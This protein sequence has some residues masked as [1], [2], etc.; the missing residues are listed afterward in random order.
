[1]IKG[2]KR[3]MRAWS[4]YDWANSVYN[5][6]ITAA[7]FPVFYSKQCPDQVEYF[8]FTLEKFQLYSY[9]LAASFLTVVIISPILSGIADYTGRKKLFMQIFCYIGASACASFY[10]FDPNHLE[11]SMLSPYFASVGFWGSSVF[12]NAYLPEIAEPKDHDK[13]SARGYILGYIGSSLLLIVC[14]VL[15]LGGGPEYT[16]YSFLMV[17]AW[18]IGFSQITFFRLPKS[19]LETSAPR[20]KILAHGFQELASVAKDIAKSKRLWRYLLAFFFFNMGV[21]TI[22]Q[23]APGYGKEEVGIPDHALIVSILL[24]QFLGAL[25]AFIMS[26]VSKRIG[27]I[28]TLLITVL[29]W[30]TICIVAYYTYTETMFYFLAAGVGFIMG[31]IQ[32]QARSTYSKFLPE[33]DEHSSYFSFYDVLEKI[34]LTISLFAFGTLNGIF[35]E[36]RTPVLM[37]VG[38]FIVGFILLLFVP[39]KQKSST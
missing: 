33:R 37:L 9:V 15:I 35:G 11:L 20:N 19:S 30:I 14:L 26:Q 32:S 39:T 4:F 38:I 36:M 13:L 17:A 2:D 8:G 6:V 34:G 22:M 16:R 7:I 5:L 12:Y 10:F 31:G 3:T 24:M 1:M 23:M 18:W 28:R 25:G 21:Q 29:L 27:N